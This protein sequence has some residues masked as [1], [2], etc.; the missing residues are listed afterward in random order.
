MT[1]GPKLNPESLKRSQRKIALR[2]VGILQRECVGNSRGSVTSKGQRQKIQKDNAGCSLVKK[3]LLS[4]H[5]DA[6]PELGRFGA[7]GS[8]NGFQKLGG[9]FVSGISCN[10]RWKRATGVSN[11]RIG[12]LIYKVSHRRFIARCCGIM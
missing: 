2:E 1:R 9:G 10:F 11:Q 5:S 4:N 7:G 12:A 8:G 6:L 3:L